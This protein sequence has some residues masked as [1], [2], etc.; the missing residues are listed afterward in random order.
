MFQYVFHYGTPGIL[1]RRSPRKLAKVYY[2]D[3][4]KER[5]HTVKGLRKKWRK[6]RANK[7]YF[8]GVLATA[9]MVCKRFE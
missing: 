3:A 1:V 6:R 4:A 7:I 5:T 9:Q 2:M 8:I